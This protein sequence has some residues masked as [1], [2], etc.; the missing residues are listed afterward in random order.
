MA[1]DPHPF[2]DMGS[3]H[4]GWDRKHFDH[5]GRTWSLLVINT[6]KSDCSGELKSMLSEATTS[7]SN[8]PAVSFW[9]THMSMTVPCRLTVDAAVSII[10]RVSMAHEAGKSAGDVEA[11]RD[12][13]RALGCGT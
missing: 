8:S 2:I 7:R 3:D 6:L 4:P 9:P 12:I 11:R 10:D 13:R 1:R 5:L